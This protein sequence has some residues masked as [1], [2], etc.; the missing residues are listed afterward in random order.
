MFHRTILRHTMLSAGLVLA[1]GSFHAIAQQDDSHRGRHY[2]VPPL[3]SRIE[4]SVVRAASGKPVEAAAVIFHPMEGESDKGSME[5]KTNE[6]GKVVIDVIPVGDTV[7]LQVIAHGFQTYGEDFKIDK[8]S[9]TM[10]VRLKRP[11]EQYSI[12]KNHDQSSDAG[13][14]AN[15]D[16]PK[17]A[18][19]PDSQPAPNPPKP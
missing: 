3:S 16:K 19:A 6:D 11:G 12:Y 14:G 4:V 1:F 5:L 13:K 7:R 18:P 15:D 9:M 2:K 8:Q 10:E 17:D